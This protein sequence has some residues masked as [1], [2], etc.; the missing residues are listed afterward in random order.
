MAGAGRHILVIGAYGLIGSAISRSLIEAGHNVTGLGRSREK[1]QAL[2]ESMSWIIE[3]LANLTI[4]ENWAPHLRGV[5]VV[6]NASGAL[7]TGL[8]DNLEVTQ[9]RS[10]AALIEACK[11]SSIT[12]FVQ[13][14]APDARD[15]SDTEFYRTKAA[16]DESLKQSGLPCTIF[17]PGLVLSSQAY[18]GTSLIRLLAAFPVVQPII[19][20]DTIIHTVDIDDVAESVH[21][22]IE[23]E[24]YGDFD[25]MSDEPTS[26]SDIV[27]G[28][29]TW[30]GFGKAKADL[31]LPLWAGKLTALGADLAGW[32]G[33]R[34][35][36]RSTCL[37]VLASGITCYSNSW[38][39]HS[40]MICK[41]FKETLSARISTAQERIYARVML[42]FPIALIIMSLFWIATGVISFFRVEAAVEILGA[43]FPTAFG[44]ILVLGGAVLDILIG[45]AMLYRPWTRK[46]C[47][48]AIGLSLAYLCASLFTAPALWLDPLGPML[49]IFPI[50]AGAGLLAAISEER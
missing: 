6:V 40:G 39:Q 10:I 17:R 9:T 41:S 42:A 2:P 43:S 27:G 13:I 37:K 24:V 44:L 21:H 26:L 47:F 33:W 16:A 34:T 31:R 14:S 22:A 20:A 49:K 4:A 7:Q 38:T 48:A 46:A 29:R 5:D 28:F 23:Q 30:L 11:A 8:K 36:L 12:H 18:G 19:L 50:M 45:L 1:A 3:D 15:D 35:A 32:L 25:L